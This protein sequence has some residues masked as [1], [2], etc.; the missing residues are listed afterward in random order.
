[1]I[2][3]KDET[4]QPSSIGQ[5]KNTNTSTIDI[6]SVNKRHHPLVKGN[7][8]SFKKLIDRNEVK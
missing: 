8:D 6:F 7:D 3:I 4:T 5:Y 2:V 1:M